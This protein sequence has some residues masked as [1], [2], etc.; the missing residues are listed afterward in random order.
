MKRIIGTYLAYVLLLVFIPLYSM[1]DEL[2]FSV[3]DYIRENGQP[4]IIYTE[5]IKKETNQTVP[6]ITL[7]LWSSNITDLQG[8]KNITGIEKVTHLNLPSNLKRAG[9]QDLP[10]SDSLKNLKLGFCDMEYLPAGFFFNSTTLKKLTIQDTSNNRSGIRLRLNPSEF[11]RENC[12]KKISLISIFYVSDSL[13]KQ[14]D[15]LETLHLVDYKNRTL[16]NAPCKNLKKFTIEED[17]LARLAVS[18]LFSRNNLKYF[19]LIGHN[20]H[21]FCG[22]QSNV[23][24]KAPKIRELQ[25]VNTGIEQLPH[26]L[27]CKQTNLRALN[28]GQN[29]NLLQIPS[30]ATAKSL[31]YLCLSDCIKLTINEGSF[32]SLMC[33]REL[34]LQNSHI[35]KIP[36]HLFHPLISLIIL[37]L[38]HNKIRHLK[39]ITFENNSKLRFLS[40]EECPLET[41]DAKVFCALKNLQTISFSG[42]P[43]D[44]RQITHLSAELISG[45]PTSLKTLSLG[46]K[47]LLSLISEHY[48]D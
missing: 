24:D 2:L 6:H 28:L 4:S 3:D 26:N 39:N 44:R 29:Y 37:D 33:L 42:H 43:E 40:L 14:F 23:F 11:S 36:D 32:D 20:N 15:V 46:N 8:L 9:S 17:H 38:S 48:L 19:T 10:S 47:Y 31:R 35:S 34:Y 18:N 12:L 1:E 25:I 7:D 41:I 27:M 45:L 16:P 22:L 13:F 30:L 5:H 21:S